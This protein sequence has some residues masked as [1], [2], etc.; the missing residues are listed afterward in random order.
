LF[1]AYKLV[2]KTGY[3]SERIASSPCASILMFHRVNDY[4]PDSLSMR[5]DVFDEMLRVLKDEYRV[6]PLSSLTDSIEGKRKI[7][8]GSVVIT[9]DDGYRDNFLYAAPLLR[10]YQLPATFFVTSGYIGTDRV[11]PWDARSAVKFQLMNWEE[12]RELNR[13]GFEIGGHTANHVNLGVVPV[14]EAMKEIVGCKEKIEEQLGKR[15]AAFAYP[16]GRSD[17]IR[18]EILPIIREAGFRCCCSGYG[19]KVTG[20][21]E[22][23][24][25]YRIPVYPTTIEL[26]ME[27]DNFMTYFDGKMRINITGRNRGECHG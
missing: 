23:F 24:N 6:V 17:C 21:N 8:A 1:S 4:G 3:L 18:D 12:V 20:E 15:I 26:L 13:S 9:F 19:G 14:D 2:K 10:K 16:F 25:L 22:L 7:E 27:I 5:V 11:F